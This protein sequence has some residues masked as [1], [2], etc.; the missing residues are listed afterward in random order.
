MCGIVGYIGN[1]P[2]KDIVLRGL[3]ALEYRG[4]DS[5]GIALI[6][7][8]DVQVFKQVGRVSAL[9][10]EVSEKANQAPLVMGHTRWA[11]HGGVTVQNAHP[12]ANNDGTIFV[13]HNGII[14]NFTDIR[15]KLQAEGYKFD[16][17]TDTEV[18]PNLVDYYLK[19]FSSFEEAFKAALNDVRGAYSIVA[20]STKEPEKLFAARL[21]SPL[22]IGVGE[23]EHIL[24]SDPSAIMD[25]TNKVI[26]LEDY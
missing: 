7:Q 3:E 13:V 4:Y 21:S 24:A 10:D 8:S 20:V 16:S 6:D 9:V 17:Q 14:E 5:A 23:G 1:K 19:Q 18:V 26:Y 22:V 2:G 15:T 11:T 12:Q 25:H